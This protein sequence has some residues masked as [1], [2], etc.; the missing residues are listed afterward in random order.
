[1]VPGPAAHQQTSTPCTAR[2]ERMFFT[3]ESAAKLVQLF[4]SLQRVLQ[5]QSSPMT[6]QGLGEFGGWRVMVLFEEVAV[7]MMAGVASDL[8]L[9][10][11][12]HKGSPCLRRTSPLSRNNT[13]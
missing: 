1:M 4:A 5:A 6:P 7:D 2:P 3:P 9:N 11:P 10:A 13:L 8:V 12:Q